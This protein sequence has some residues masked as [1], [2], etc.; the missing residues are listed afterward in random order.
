MYYAKGNYSLEM[1]KKLDKNAWNKLPSQ[2][3][4]DIRLALDESIVYAKGKEKQELMQ[5]KTKL[6]KFSFL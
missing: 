5:I 4:S 1:L 6:I 3:R 2:T